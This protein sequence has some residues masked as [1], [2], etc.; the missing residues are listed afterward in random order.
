[1]VTKNAD[2]YSSTIPSGLHQVYPNK[3]ILHY[4][5]TLGKNPEPSCMNH[6]QKDQ[7]DQCSILHERASLVTNQIQVLL[8]TSHNC[9]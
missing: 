6:L 1:M 8:Y 2:V 4:Q 9:V 7:K 3:H 5:Q